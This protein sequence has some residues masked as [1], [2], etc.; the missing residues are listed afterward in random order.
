MRVE[1]EE[2]K[3]FFRDDGNLDGI[4]DGAD[5]KGKKKKLSPL[6][7][8]AILL[9]PVWAYVTFFMDVGT[10]PYSA[11][12]SKE[13]KGTIV[14][15]EPFLEITDADVLWM[16][17]ISEM[18]EV[19]EAIEK[20]D[21]GEEKYVSHFIPYA[22]LP[23]ENRPDMEFDNVFYSVSKTDDEMTWYIY[24][25]VDVPDSVGGYKNY[26]MNINNKDN[27]FKNV[28]VYDRS[29][30]Q[31]LYYSSDGYSVF[32]SVFKYRKGLI[33]LLLPSDSDD[34]G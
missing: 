1:V 24:A 34:N 7:I 13:S 32:K 30:R 12:F 22:E 2:D 17:S 8:A 9:I 29:G 6:K 15:Q 21:S 25:D 23:A 4:P 10:E 5:G 3:G 31:R 20:V 11:E 26:D 33:S 16:K 18:P 28:S 27:F 14:A 19:Q